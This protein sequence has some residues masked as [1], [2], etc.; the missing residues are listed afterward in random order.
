[1]DRGGPEIS[2]IQM[3][4]LHFDVLDVPDTGGDLDTQTTSA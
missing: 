2:D 1:M 4:G 3:L